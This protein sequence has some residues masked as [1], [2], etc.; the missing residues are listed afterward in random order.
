MREVAG[1]L[2]YSA[3]AIYQHFASK[4]DLL[5]ALKL[6][7]GDLLATEM[8]VARQEP[9]LEAQLHAMGQR[10]LRFGLENPAY[11]RL[12]FQDSVPGLEPTPEQLARMR[13]SWAIMRDTLRAW[14]ETRSLPGVDADQEADV[15]WAMVHGI[16]SLAL[17]GRLPFSDQREI[18]ALFDLAAG[19]WMSG[20]LNV[21]PTRPLRAAKKRRHY[22]SSG[23]SSRRL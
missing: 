19:H 23:R 20:V 8:E 13:R 18:F 4:E 9:T 15:L 11:Y 7:A 2:D 22:R 21:Q 16:T 6:Q 3:T 1:A 5:L 14:I 17:A 12:I 10:Y